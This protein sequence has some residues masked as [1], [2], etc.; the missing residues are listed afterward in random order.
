MEHGS[1][2]RKDFVM[3]LILYDKELDCIKY[4]VMK[5]FGDSTRFPRNDKD[6]NE[7]LLS[8]AG[9]YYDKTNYQIVD[10]YNILDLEGNTLWVEEDLWVNPIN[11]LE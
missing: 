3:L 10:V 2:E 9:K 1:R 7:V 4:G 5:A 11:S 6:D 8:I